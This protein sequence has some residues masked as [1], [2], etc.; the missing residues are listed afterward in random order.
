V[1]RKTIDASQ[2]VDPDEMDFEGQEWLMP[3]NAEP[4]PEK[5]RTGASFQLS[6]LYVPWQLLLLYAVVPGAASL[7]YA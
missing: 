1:Q 2:Y 6:L 3:E 5:V 7:L 4:K